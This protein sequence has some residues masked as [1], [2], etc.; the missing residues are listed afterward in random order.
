[1]SISRHL[2][3]LVDGH[4]G[5]PRRLC[6][7]CGRRRRLDGAGRRLCRGPARALRACGRMT[8]RCAWPS[9]TAR[10]ACAPSSRCRPAQ[11]SYPSVAAHHP[12][13]LRLERAMRDLYGVQPDR[14]ARSPA[15]ARSRPL[16]RAAERGALRIPAGR[17][18]GL[19]PDTRRAGPCRH[20]RAGP[21]PFHR[22]WRD[23]R[24]ARGEAG[25]RAQ[26]RRRPDGRRRDRSRPRASS[27]ASRATARWPMPGRSPAPS[28][29]RSAGRRR[30]APC[31]C[32]ASWPSWSAWRTTSA[33]SARSATT[34]A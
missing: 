24:A 23:G 7:A 13:A 8:T 19:A 12:P 21:F 34:P 4:A 20:H 2:A 15:L 33:T 28:R 32:A 1:M 18:R 3:N 17:G 10:G 16:A 22:Q 5:R 9:A 11:A 26:G 14:P 30:R 27:G 29:R 25:L 6:P 31:C